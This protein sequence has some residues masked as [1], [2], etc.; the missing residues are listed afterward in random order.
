MN[1]LGIETSADDT[2][3]AVVKNGRK[4]LSN[5]VSS[6]AHIHSKYG[7]IIPEQAARQHIKN[8]IPTIDLSLKVAKTKLSEIDVFAATGASNAGVFINII[9]GV[10]TAATLAHFLNKPFVLT[11]HMEAHIFANFPEHK[12]LRFPFLA[13]VVSGGHTM[14][15][16]AKKHGHYELLGETRDDAAGEAFD[17]VGR[18]I[19]LKY[20]AGPK[21]DKLAKEGD[22]KGFDF[23]RPMI[24][25][26]DYDFSFSGLKTSVMTKIKFEKINIKK[27]KKDLAASFQQSIVDVLVYK[28]IRALKEKGSS[29]LIIGGGV[30]A[31]SQLRV[32]FS[33][34]AE[35]LGFEFFCPSLNLCTDN[36]VGVA[37]LGYFKHKHKDVENP[38]D[39]D[40]VF[41]KGLGV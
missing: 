28:T 33:K 36:A 18:M 17:K 35:K 24:G 11:N 20:P 13:L 29:R 12:S 16:W 27:H 4:I 26:N 21:I 22:K 37:S 8:V 30:A 38:L 31:N 25:S 23:P 19:G 41:K 40:P 15:I 9:V 5:I 10:Q 6:Q 14:L 2:C 7:G 1:I 34:K 3:A 32:A 39:F